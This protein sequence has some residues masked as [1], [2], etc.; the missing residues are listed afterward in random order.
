MAA[1]RSEAVML[2]GAPASSDPGGSRARSILELLAGIPGGACIALAATLLSCIG[3]QGLWAQ[4]APQKLTVQRS[5]RAI[6]HRFIVHPSEA[7]VPVNQTQRFEVTDAQ[8]TPVAVHWNVSGLGCSGLE[9]GTIDE[10]G[11]YRTPSSLPQPRVVTVEGVLVSDPNYSV[12]TQVWLEDSASAAA[13]AAHAQVASRETK[14]LTAPKVGAQNLAADR[15]SPPR[16]SVVPAAPAIGKQVVTTAELLPLPNPVGAVPTVRNQVARGAASPLAPDVVAPSPDVRAR[17]ARG[18]VSPPPPNVV[19]AAPAVGRQTVSSAEL[20]PLPNPVGAAPTVGNQVARSAA[21]PPLPKVI[22]PAPAVGRQTV[23]SAELLPLPNP[24]GA[25]PTVGNQVARSAAAPPLPKAIAPAPAVGRQTV[26]SAELLPLPNP[27]GA[28]PTV[29][30]Q[31]TRNSASPPLPKVIAPAPT[32]GKKLVI[33]AELMPLTNPV[34]A[35][36]VVGKQAVRNAGSSLAP[37]VVA[38]PPSVGIPAARGAALA[39]LPNAVAAAPTLGKPVS[40]SAEPLP[41][42]VV[43][44]A[45]A[46]GRQDL[47]NS[48]GSPPLPN[49]IAAAAPTV[50]NQVAR[51]AGSP[52]LPD[53][54]PAPAAARQNLPSSEGS[55]PAASVVAALSPLPDPLSAG[56]TQTLA[57]TAAGRQSS[58]GSGV[59]MPMPELSAAVPPGSAAPAQHAP[60]VTYRDGQLTIDAENLTLAAVLDL[61]AQKT[62]A[63]IEVPPG[64]GQERV[65][66]HAGPGPVN[67]VL[68]R[69]L[70][71]SPFNYIIVNSPQH[72]NQP[73]Q[74]LLSLHG[75]D[76]ETPS[77]A[78]VQPKPASPPVLWTPPPDSSSAALLP[79]VDRSGLVVPPRESTTPEALGE[80]IRERGRQLREQLQ[81]QQ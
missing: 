57:A 77:V 29:G 18:A 64:S 30:K 10:Q 73:A 74:V 49:V 28:A 23:T 56:R 61:I 40:R 11:I 34:G 35:A 26:T 76:I 12:L 22:A 55:P 63:V 51:S 6:P 53:A 59:L 58:A 16:P 27:V 52:A 41:P 8:G 60:V 65:F 25:A 71:G 31:P 15:G 37:N 3:G 69:L 20:L 54:V 24:V 62:G 1:R 32:V 47:P 66:E 42:N 39:P 36:P 17:A 70:N 79:Q 33:D 50:G 45:P 21:A 75:P 46:V 14:A 13:N 80:L 2:R 78:S 72:P 48:G 81:K 5:T 9:C 67:D 19:A 44:P 38:P 68:E 4:G 7:V 43:A